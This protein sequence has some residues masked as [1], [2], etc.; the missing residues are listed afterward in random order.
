MKALRHTRIAAAACTALVTVLGTSALASPVEHAVDVTNAAD[1]VR[2]RYG[3]HTVN[4]RLATPLEADGFTFVGSVGDQIQI[5][6][7]TLSAGLD[8]SMMLRGPSG[9]IVKSVDCAGN[10]VYGTP[11]LCSTALSHTLV[12]AGLYTFNVADVGANEAGAY[13]LHMDRYPPIN[14]WAGLAYGGNNQK[15]TDIGH[16]TDSDYFAFNG[17]AGTDVRVTVGTTSP[18]LDPVL[19]IWSPAGARISKTVCEGNNIYGTPILCTNLVDL[20]LTTTGVYRVGVYDSGWDEAGNY[21]LLVGCLFGNCPSVNS[22]PPMPVPEPDSIALLIGG[23]GWLGFATRR[24]IP[25]VGAI[26]C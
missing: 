11:I 13:Q 9:A 15:V 1:F 18:G 23:L 20:H 25:P 19:D 24:R 7:H 14:N 10:N 17:I 5:A 21:K 16:T 26:R 12:E 6:L 3:D 4:A 8:A 22:P 2:L